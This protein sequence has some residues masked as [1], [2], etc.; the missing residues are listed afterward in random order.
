MYPK[1]TQYSNKTIWIA[2]HLYNLYSIKKILFWEIEMKESAVMFRWVSRSS[3]VRGRRSTSC[4]VQRYM[5]KRLLCTQ[6][7]WWTDPLLD[8]GKGH[9]AV[10]CRYQLAPDGFHQQVSTGQGQ[11]GRDHEKMVK[12]CDRCNAVGI[13]LVPRWTV[14]G[15]LTSHPVMWKLMWWIRTR[16]ETRIKLNR[17]LNINK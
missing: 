16:Q 7:R 10:C 11:L 9:Y 8:L 4:Q 15:L 17:G 14:A 1:C 6:F 2:S 12:Y 13:T 3:R 5:K